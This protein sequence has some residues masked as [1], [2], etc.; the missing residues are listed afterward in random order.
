MYHL[1]GFPVDFEM[2]AESFGSMRMDI[3]DYIVRRT[4][5]AGDGFYVLSLIRVVHRYDIYKDR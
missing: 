3:G 4:D 1:L 5:V 2:L